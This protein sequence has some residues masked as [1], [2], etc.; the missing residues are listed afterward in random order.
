M[1]PRIP[2]LAPCLVLLVAC[3]ADRRRA[4][5]LAALRD[6][7]AVLPAA[8]GEA[9]DSDSLSST[10]PVVEFTEAGGPGVVPVLGA[11]LDSAVAEIGQ[12]ALLLGSV[13]PLAFVRSRT[14][15]FS[16]GAHGTTADSFQVIDLARRG[17]A[18]LLDDSARAAV[19]EAY[20]ADATSAFLADSSPEPPETDSMF[21]SMVVPRLRGERLELAYQFSAYSCYICSDFRWSAYTRSVQ[22][23]ARELPPLLNAFAAVPLE[24]QT[25]LRVTRAAPD[26]GAGWSEVV[27]PAARR[28][29]LARL[30]G[31]TAPA[32][33]REFLVW[34]RTGPGAFETVW[35]RG[36]GVE[37]T[38][39]GRQ[40]AAW[41]VAGGRA[42]S[43][44]SRDVRVPTVPCSKQVD[45][46]MP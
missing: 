16:C 10:V 1:I 24:V 38:I 5:D 18:A 35:L 32:G 15:L 2:V 29:A 14:W 30:F 36:A 3:G 7:A 46:E 22:L 17:P 41:I 40:P 25:A 6:S 37:A 12:E 27:M 28:D 31:V 23:P 13:G 21:L 45:M 34:R 26:S 43:W 9:P 8:P 42:W 44:H 39:V 20:R 19:V 4:P 33:G 11:P